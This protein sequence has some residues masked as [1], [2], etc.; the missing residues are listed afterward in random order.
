M[1]ICYH[2][3]LIYFRDVWNITQD[4]SIEFL[5]TRDH[6]WDALAVTLAVVQFPVHFDKKTGL[7][8]GNG[9]RARIYDHKLWI[10]L[11]RSLA[12]REFPGRGLFFLA[13]QQEPQNP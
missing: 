12:F 6:F 11:Q 5:K 13:L 4:F 8:W 1:S 2:L 7:H 3:N 9:A 10:D